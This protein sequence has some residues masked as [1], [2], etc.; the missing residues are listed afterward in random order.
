MNIEQRRY[1]EM[2]AEVRLSEDRKVKLEEIMR[3]ESGHKRNFSFKKY[4]VIVSCA[5]MM[6]SC[7]C[8]A[9][10]QVA[11]AMKEKTVK[12]M[13]EE[14]GDIITDNSRGEGIPNR[15]TAITKEVT[16]L[17]DGEPVVWEI[18]ASLYLDENGEVDIELFNH[19][20]M[21]SFFVYAEQLYANTEWNCSGWSIVCGSD[22]EGNQY[23]EAKTP[24]IPIN[25]FAWSFME[26]NGRWYLMV[27]RN[28]EF[29][30]NISVAECGDKGLG[31]LLPNAFVS[32]EV[33]LYDFTYNGEEYTVAALGEHKIEIL[34]KK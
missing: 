19:A 9:S 12:E 4:A 1:K 33:I 26:Y 5:V 2:V 20:I 10:V 11:K 21:D 22:D 27:P 16:L 31:I 15:V 34:R 23:Y 13:L 14:K 8:M 32:G 6:L 28:V 18:D 29:D 17:V 7:I 3:M 30:M 24:N 25:P